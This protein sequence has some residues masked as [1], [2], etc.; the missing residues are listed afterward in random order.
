MKPSDPGSSWAKPAK[1]R[2][3]LKRKDLAPERAGRFQG[4]LAAGFR[5]AQINREIRAAR[6]KEGSGPKPIVRCKG[7]GLWVTDTPAGR[8]RHQARTGC[9]AT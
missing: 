1:R 8:A 3:G 4:Q 7:C 5:Q 6:A 2:R 9:V